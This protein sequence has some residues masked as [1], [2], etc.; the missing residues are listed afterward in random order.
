MRNDTPTPLPPAFRAMADGTR[1]KI[2]LMLE[3]KARTVGEIVDF[4]DLSQPTITRHLQALL[5][6]GL[7]TRR[8]RGQR[9]EYRLNA[10]SLRSVCVNLVACFPCCEISIRPTGGKVVCRTASDEL[11]VVS[12]E[13]E[14]GRRKT[15]TIKN[16]R[17]GGRP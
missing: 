1:L 7:V 13:R 8:R 3:A 5:A 17:K 6:A 15:E 16:R 2:L 9:V 14:P 10:D 4:F 12:R 11:P